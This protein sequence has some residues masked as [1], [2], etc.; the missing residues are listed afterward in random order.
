MSIFSRV[1]DAVE[2]HINAENV[3]TEI[4]NGVSREQ[5]D[6]LYERGRKIGLLAAYIESGDPGFKWQIEHYSELFNPDGTPKD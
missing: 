2:G 6:R 4:G 1:K 3:A 5:L